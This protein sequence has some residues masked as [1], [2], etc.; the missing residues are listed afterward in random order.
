MGLLLVMKTLNLNQVKTF[1]KLAHAK[2]FRR[3]GVT[4]Y[5]T[6]LEGVAKLDGYLSDEEAMVAYL[7][8]IL[9]DYKY[10]N[11]TIEDLLNI[12]IKRKV[13]AAVIA[14]T[15]LENESNEEYWLKV[16]HN[17]MAVKVKLLDMAYNY[18][19]SPTENQKKKYDAGFEFFKNLGLE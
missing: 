1:A 4:P 3:D 18:A 10:T 12:G 13:I 15:K 5:F 17:K 2:H 9:E 19:D 16:S 14:I 8:D 11:V 7:H 6:H